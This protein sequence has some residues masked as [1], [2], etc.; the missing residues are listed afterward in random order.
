M[1]TGTVKDAQTG[2][3]LRN[4]KVSAG[5][6]ADTQTN[7]SGAYTLSRVPAGLVVVSASLP[8]YINGS[9]TADLVAGGNATAN[10]SL[11]PLPTGTGD[12]DGDGVPDN[13]DQ[14]P[15]TPSGDTVGSNGCPTSGTDTDSDNDGIPD[16]SD[17]CPNTP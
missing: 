16:S 12:T 4:A 11:E 3:P 8:G 6:T 10:I 5:G 7:S 1:I 2:Q 15:N 17:Q 9:T 14:C 13:Q